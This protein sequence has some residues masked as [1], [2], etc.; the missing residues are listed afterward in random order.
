VE[1]ASRVTAVRTYFSWIKNNAMMQMSELVGFAALQFISLR[2]ASSLHREVIM[3]DQEITHRLR[4]VRYG[5]IVVTVTVFVFL[6][7]FAVVVGTQIDAQTG[8]S[9]T[10]GLL[11]SMLGYI[12]G[13]TVLAAILSVILYFVYRAYLMGRTVKAA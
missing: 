3:A 12:I 1:A 11:N 8:A 5:G 4:L 10:G 2:G 6:L 9:V 13:F 7:A